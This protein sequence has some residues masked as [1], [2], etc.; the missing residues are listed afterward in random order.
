M[1]PELYIS[2]TKGLEDDV[3]ALEMLKDS[4]MIAGIEGNLD[5]DSIVKDKELW[6]EI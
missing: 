2:S 6:S 5:I 4:E 3:T 1:H